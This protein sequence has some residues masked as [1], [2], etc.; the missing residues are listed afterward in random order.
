MGG[1]LRAVIGSGATLAAVAI[2]VGGGGAT[3][4][5][6]PPQNTAKPTI[7]GTP[8][9][10]QTLSATTGSW[11]EPEPISFAYHWLRCDQ[12]GNGCSRITGARSQTYKTAA[13]HVVH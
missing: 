2:L 1:R 9:E 13:T 5:T 8:T 11:T 7:S 3:A 12:N 4:A 6:T 10:G